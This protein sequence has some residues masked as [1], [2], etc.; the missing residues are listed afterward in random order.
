MHSKKLITVLIIL[1]VVVIIY[2]VVVYPL[3]RKEHFK[4]V[5][6]NI[7]DKLVFDQNGIEKNRTKLYGSL[8][9]DNLKT[10]IKKMTDPRIEYD[11]KQITLLRYSDILL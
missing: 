11:D 10:Q 1:I 5:I 8:F 9:L 2:L 6:W 7:D 4:D 3:S